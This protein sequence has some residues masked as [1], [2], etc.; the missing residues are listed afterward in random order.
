LKDLLNA[1]VNEN[2]I[3]VKKETGGL[4]YKDWWLSLR[5]ASDAREMVSRKERRVARSER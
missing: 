3:F 5:G 4:A 1:G 2:F